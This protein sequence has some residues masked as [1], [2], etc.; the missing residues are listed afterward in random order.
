[1]HISS[2]LRGV[3]LTIRLDIMAAIFCVSMS[4]WL[5][6]GLRCRRDTLVDANT[7]KLLGGDPHLCPLWDL[8]PCVF[9]MKIRCGVLRYQ[10]SPMPYSKK[11]S[12]ISA[13][14]YVRAY[15][16]TGI[17]DHVELFLPSARPRVQY[18]LNLD[19]AH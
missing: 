7:I 16:A 17:V 2:I 8:P 14:F 9:A 6:Y 10:Q 4:T 13:T 11:P 18:L 12:A 1:M 15:A 19:G 5:A 3:V